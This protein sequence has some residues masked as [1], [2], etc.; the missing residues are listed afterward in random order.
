MS[1]QELMQEHIANWRKSGQTMADYCQANKIKV[2]T[3]HYWRKKISQSHASPSEFITIQ[4]N[5]NVGVPK[6]VRISYHNGV[7]VELPQD[8][9]AEL[10][11]TLIHI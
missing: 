7:Q 6:S 1:K 3:F 9:S 5:R 8:S 2:C 4:S 11:R 10:I